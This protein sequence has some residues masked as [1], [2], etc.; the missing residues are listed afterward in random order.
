MQFDP[1]TEILDLKSKPFL[2]NGVPITLGSVIS[3]SI[4]KVRC[5]VEFKKNLYMISKI[6]LSA[7]NKKDIVKIDDPK[8]ST[9][10]LESVWSHPIY[11]IDLLGCAYEELELQLSDT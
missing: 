8:T 5:P 3:E 1:N 11:D 6:V 4:V 7:I 10:I 9:I 2:I